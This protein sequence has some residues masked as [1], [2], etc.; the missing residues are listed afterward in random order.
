MTS[1]SL[2]DIH[3]SCWDDATQSRLGGFLTKTVEATNDIVA[4]A[5]RMLSGRAPPDIGLLLHAYVC[6]VGSYADSTRYR[7]R[8]IADEVGQ[9]HGLLPRG[10]S[11]FEHVWSVKREAVEQY[12]AWVAPLLL[13]GRANVGLEGVQ[14]LDPCPNDAMDLRLPPPLGGLIRRPWRAPFRV[15]ATDDAIAYV[16]PFQYQVLSKDGNAYWI[17]GSPRA[18]S[19]ASI[20]EMPVEETDKNIV[21]VQDRFVFSNL[22][23]FLFDGVT[24][25]LHYV[26]TFGV[27]DK[28]LFILGSIPRKYQNLVCTALSEYAGIAPENL[29]FPVGPHLLSTSRKCFWFSDQMEGHVHPAQMAHP[30]SIGALA[31]FCATLP[32]AG[33]AGKRVY[34]S[35]GDATRRRIANEDD[36]IAAL[37]GRGFR[38]VQLAKL[39]AN[40]QIGIFRDAEIVVGPHGMGLTQIIMGSKLGRLIELFHSNAGTDAYAFVARAAGMQY[41]F[42]SGPEVPKTSGDFSIDVGKVLDLLGPDDTP[43]HTPSWRRNANLIPASRTFQGFFLIGASR[44]EAYADQMIWGHEARLHRRRGNAREVGRWPHILISPGRHY[45]ASCWI[46]IS[47]EFTGTR[48]AMRVGDWSEQT[49]HAANLSLTEGW[50]RIWT[51]GMAPEKDRTWVALEIDGVDDDAVASCCWQFESG[52]VPGA[53]SGTG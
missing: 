7:M 31:E 34:V 36:L 1:H 10:G 17:T 45:T 6:G 4:L 37:Q 32:G 9:A 23:H 12:C 41:D 29:F 16:H 40:E 44:L 20:P 14:V 18:L 38:S 35:R 3:A 51:T 49:Q 25:I 2:A 28:D 21:I 22:C 43:R 30:R 46:R 39:P 11:F 33:G 15:Y 26:E 5:H 27:S 48:V 8:Q 13:T 50:Q 42:L 24:R 53:Y 47:S 19:R 52:Q